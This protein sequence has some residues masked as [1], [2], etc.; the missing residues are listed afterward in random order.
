MRYRI[1][2][3]ILQRSLVKLPNLVID[4]DYDYLSLVK[5]KTIKNL[6]CGDINHLP[7]PNNLF[8]LVTANMVFEHLNNPQQSLNEISRVLKIGGKLIFHTPN[9][10]VILLW[11]RE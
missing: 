7:F 9:K 3:E 6:V 1:F 2:H 11:H 8:D 5:H 4:L 10:W